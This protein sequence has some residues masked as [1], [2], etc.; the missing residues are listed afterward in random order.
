M[1]EIVVAFLFLVTP[2]NTLELQSVAKMPYDACI[3]QARDIN[4]DS[5]H[6]YVM[7]CGPDLAIATH[8]S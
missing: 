4:S 8:E 2:T 1:V 7:L 6:P 5:S 3:S